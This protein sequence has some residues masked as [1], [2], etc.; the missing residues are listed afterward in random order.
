MPAT[1]IVFFAEHGVIPVLDWLEDL[2][3]QDKRAA[4]ECI[5]R[6]RLLAQFGHELRRPHADILRDGIYELRAKRGRVQYRILYFFHGRNI[7]IL[8]HALTKEDKV[9][10]I[11]IHRAIER[12]RKYEQNPTQHTGDETIPQN[13]DD[14]GR[15]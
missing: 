8:A 5:A 4:A 1:Q 3:R 2:Y 13:P 15:A 12:M 9:P 14:L 10:V 11:D 6:I 7:A